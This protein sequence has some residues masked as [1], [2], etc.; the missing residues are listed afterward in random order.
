V[1]GMWFDLSDAGNLTHTVEIEILVI[2]GVVGLDVARR[3][4][5]RA[6]RA[7]ATPDS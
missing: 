3:R 5:R 7:A 4:W 6:R 2:A 1:R